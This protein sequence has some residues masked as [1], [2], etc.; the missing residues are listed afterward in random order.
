MM[1]QSQTF[2]WFF[3]FILVASFLY[4]TPALAQEKEQY[5]SVKEA[6]QSSSKLRGS[7]GPRNVNWI[8]GGD[9]YSYMQYN[10]DTESTE[11]RAYNPANEEDVLIFNNK[12]YTFPDSDKTFDYRS[13]QWSKDSKYIVFQSNFRP[14]YRRSG[15]SDYYLYSIDEDQ[16]QL[17]V[18]DARTAE[19]SP[20]G[21]KIGY[22]REGDLFVYNLNSGSEK[23]LTDSGG[24][25]FYNGRFG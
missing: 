21:T 24:E 6:L 23:Q 20:D 3:L 1:Q 13:F 18:K 10:S 19:L 11:I 8:D 7:S 4:E 14:V 17:L 5:E 16:L 25:N 12:E 22:E 2:K 15:I 9:R